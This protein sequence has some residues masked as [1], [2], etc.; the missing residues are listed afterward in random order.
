MLV[1]FCLFG[2]FT[3]ITPFSFSMSLPP[4]LTSPLKINGWKIFFSYPGARM[5]PQVITF[6]FGPISG[7][8]G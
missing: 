7:F 5:T 2:R 6:G 8:G 3:L 1:L 4:K